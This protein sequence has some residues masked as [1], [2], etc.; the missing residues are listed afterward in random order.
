[1]QFEER[2]EGNV[3]IVK[4]LNK[5]LDALE[6]SDFKE[7]MS[8]YISSGSNLI[9]LNIS[10]VDFVGSSGLGAMVSVLKML[11]GDGRL[12][13]CGTTEKVMRMFKLTRMNKIFS[14]FESEE[15]AIN[16]LSE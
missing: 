12:A 4:I 2:K 16:S 10:E 15:E 8:E 11:V 7:K 1:M 13:I 6:A 3:Q 5:R 9:V 14:I